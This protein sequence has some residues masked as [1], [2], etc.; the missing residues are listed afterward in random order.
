[1][2]QEAIPTLKNLLSKK[3]WSSSYLDSDKN[4]PDILLTNPSI[5]EFQGRVIVAQRKLNNISGKLAFSWR[6]NRSSIVLH[7]LSIETGMTDF[8]KE[9]DVSMISNFCSIEDP[10][11]NIF[12]AKLEIWACGWKFSKSNQVIIQQVLIKLDKNFDVESYIVFDEY[13]DMEY[14]PEKNWQPILNSDLYIYKAQHEHIVISRSSKKRYISK[15]LSWDFGEIHGGTQVI[16]HK[17]VN[18][19]FFQSSLPLNA[20]DTNNNQ[21]PSKYFV[22]AYCFEVEPP[23]KI[24]EFSS[25]PIIEASFDNKAIHGSPAVLFP[26]GLMS[27]NNEI[28]LSIGV[29]DCSSFIL[30]IPHNEISTFLNFDQ[31]KP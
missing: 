17:G 22:G 5:I 25:K 4:F 14:I 15:G 7:Y 11:L 27:H 18:L 12:N 2:I 30:R 13:D 3:N 6:E 24:I 26:S 9:I 1:L 8:I 23:F 20:A 21:F 10:R 16:E 31:L 19:C 28:I 29:N